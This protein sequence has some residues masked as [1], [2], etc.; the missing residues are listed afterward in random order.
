MKKHITLFLLLLAQL[1][2]ANTAEPD[3]STPDKL[4]SAF[5]ACLNVEPGKTIDSL[6]FTK[7]FYYSNAQI[8]AVLP[9]R[10]D[11]SK[12]NCYSM[13]TTQYLAGMKTHTATNRFWEW[14]TGRQSISYANQTTIYS[15]YALID[16]DSKGDTTKETGINILHLFFDG[17]RWWILQC[18]YE[19]ETKKH[20]IPD[21]YYKKED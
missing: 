11:S 20:P 13:L 7:L 5:Y 3:Y 12:T 19:E 10:K 17:K 21:A 2:S 4:I 15:A 14:E 9:S 1:G 8:A 6:Q 16:V 18:S